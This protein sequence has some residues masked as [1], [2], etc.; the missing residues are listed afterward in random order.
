MNEQ[1]TASSVRCLSVEN[2]RSHNNNKHGDVNEQMH[3]VVFKCV[4]GFFRL[5]V[6]LLQIQ[7]HCCEASDTTQPE[8]I[9]LQFRGTFAVQKQVSDE[10]RWQCM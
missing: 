7:M 4:L 5:D 8:I 9:F 3:S 2:A 6:N 10:M 1:K